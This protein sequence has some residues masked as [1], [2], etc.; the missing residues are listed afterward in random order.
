[1]LFRYSAL[2]FYGHRIHYDA[3]YTRKT[4]GYPGLVVHGPL[5]ATLLI[6]LGL[7]RLGSRRITHFDIRAMSPLFDTAPFRLE[8]R[9]TKE[10]VALWARA[11]DG[12]TAMTV[13]LHA[14]H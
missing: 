9:D 2:I 3:S 12:T 11:P 8:G 4:E 10:G 5:T 13:T 6:G 7:K 1:M 14:S